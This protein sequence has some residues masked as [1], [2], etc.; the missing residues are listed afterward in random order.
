MR[1]YMGGII[2]IYWYRARLYINRR[3]CE[4]VFLKSDSA[5]YAPGD[6]I[7][8]RYVSGFLVTLFVSHSYGT[9]KPAALI[10]LDKT[11]RAPAFPIIISEV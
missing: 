3:F 11:A 7:E 6:K 2:L 10:E 8:K 9:E 4:H 5:N 1:A